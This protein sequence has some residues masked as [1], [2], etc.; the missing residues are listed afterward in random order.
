[1]RPLAKFVRA[2]IEGV[3]RTGAAREAV[4]PGIVVS[5]APRLVGMRDD[6]GAPVRSLEKAF[7]FVNTSA[8]HSPRPC[9]RPRAA[10]ARLPPHDVVVV[11]VI[12]SIRT[13]TPG[14]ILQT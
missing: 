2:K 7:S 14:H 6:E 1:M 5:V 11:V 10:P 3:L 13:R 8:L 12:E 4:E 9:A